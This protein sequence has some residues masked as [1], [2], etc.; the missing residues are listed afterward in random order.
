MRKAHLKIFLTVKLSHFRG[1]NMVFSKLLILV[2]SFAYGVFVYKVYR[3][4]FR[5]AELD[6]AVENVKDWE[7]RQDIARMVKRVK[8]IK[9]DKNV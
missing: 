8:K 3:K 2:V 9:G 4:F 7:L 1:G 5:E 6:E